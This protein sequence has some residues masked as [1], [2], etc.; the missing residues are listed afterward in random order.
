MVR[1]S[2]YS[3]LGKSLLIFMLKY[4]IL[5]KMRKNVY[6]IIAYGEALTPKLLFLFG[7]R[8]SVSYQSANI[9]MCRGFLGQSFNWTSY[10]NKCMNYN[11]SVQCQ[12][13]F[14]KRFSED[15][16]SDSEKRRDD[17]SQS[18][19]GQKKTSVKVK[20]LPLPVQKVLSPEAL[21]SSSKDRF[22]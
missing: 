10:Y 3:Y 1:H 20:S 14:A 11:N 6:L 5:L 8:V 16:R 21:F 18:R 12:S 2:L 9:I 22:L 7:W 17:C 19:R 15:G 13:F 4:C